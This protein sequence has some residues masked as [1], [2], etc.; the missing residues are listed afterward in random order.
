MT[1]KDNQN[2]GVRRMVPKIVGELQ[3]TVE[4]SPRIKKAIAETHRENQKKIQKESMGK[5]KTIRQKTAK[6][7]MKALIK[8]YK[9]VLK[10]LNNL[11]NQKIQAIKSHPKIQYKKAVK[12]MKFTISK[13]I[14]AKKSKILANKGKHMLPFSTNARAKKTSARR[15]K[16]MT[17]S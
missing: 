8:T 6:T 5:M 3:R 2:Q 16:F 11:I 15:M 10:I 12:K 14:G 9:A 1:Q 7:I 13:K 17:R 4:R